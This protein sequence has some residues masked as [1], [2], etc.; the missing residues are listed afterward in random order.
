MCARATSAGHQGR[1]SRASARAREWLAD[2][3]A[4]ILPRLGGGDRQWARAEG[5]RADRASW[6][7]SGRSP[8]GSVAVSAASSAAAGPRSAAPPGRKKRPRVGRGQVRTAQ[9]GAAHRQSGVRTL[10]TGSS[11][12]LASRRA[13]I[14]QTDDWEKN[15][16][17]GAPTRPTTKGRRRGVTLCAANLEVPDLRLREATGLRDSHGRLR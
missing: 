17:R 12:L 15:T 2:G 3:L 11:S 9:P 13:V 14:I 1:R 6:A 4:R 7:C 8:I 10:C 5:P 16:A